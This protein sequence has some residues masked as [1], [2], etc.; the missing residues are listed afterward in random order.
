[1]EKIHLGKLN[2]DKF[3]LDLKFKSITT[4]WFV[5]VFLIVAVFVTVAA[6]AFS[7]LFRSI[8]YERVEVLASDYSYEFSSLEGA[9]KS[10]FKDSAIN[11]AGEFVHKTKIEVQVLD[12]NGETLVSTSGYE[13][14]HTDLTDFERCKE[15]G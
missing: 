2:V 8:Y 9:N 4:R 6:V 14:V 5:N 15:N 1:M 11:L 7:L 10:N 13:S 12:N 3:H